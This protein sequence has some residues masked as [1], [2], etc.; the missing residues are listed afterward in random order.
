MPCCLFAEQDYA[1]AL[2]LYR[3]LD[4]IHP[5]RAQTHA[6]LGATLYYLGRADEAL[7]RFE[8]ALSLD[9]TLETARTA[10]DQLRRLTRPLAPDGASNYDHGKSCDV[11]RHVGRRQ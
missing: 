2:A 6:N 5:D 8:H 11:I 4:E 10:R 9:P 1:E 3:T 7:R